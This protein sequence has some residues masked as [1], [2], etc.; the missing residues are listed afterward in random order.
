MRG[1]RALLLLL[2]LLAVAIAIAF[3]VSDGTG[4][5]PRLP[6]RRP[7]LLLLTSLPIMFGEDFSLS[8]SG[9]PVI[10]RLQSRYKVVPI[11]V[12]DASELAQGRLMLMAQPRAQTAENLVAL[13]HWVRSGG[14]LLL[15]ADPLLEWPSKFPLGD[16]ARPLPVFMDSGLLLHW[17]LRLDPPNAFGAAKRK[18]AGYSIETFSPG[19][20]HGECKISDDGLVARCGIDKGI[21]II[22]ADA[23]FLNTPALGD[24]GRHNL[25]GLLALLASL[26]QS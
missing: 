19:N 16:V 13:D 1:R 11:S 25:D 26:E 3:L 7:K 10:K 12:T 20:L 4:N 9:S 17:G 14:H 2:I 8:G 18:L 6:S 21:A 24:A 22:V 23:D 15:L 5:P